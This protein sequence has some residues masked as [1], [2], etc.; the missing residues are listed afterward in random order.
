MNWLNIA[1]STGDDCVSIGDM[2]SNI[3]VSFVNC[4]PGHGVRWVIYLR[5]FFH[6]RNPLF[7][8]SN[9]LDFGKKNNKILLCLAIHSTL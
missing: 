3:N 6:A 2:T 9:P 8:Q 1:Q 7:L 5:H 4:G